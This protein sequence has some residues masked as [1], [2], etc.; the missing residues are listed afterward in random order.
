MCCVVVGVQG[1]VCV[2]VQ[3]VK[4]E[5][6]KS[7]KKEREKC[8]RVVGC[9]LLFLLELGNRELKGRIGSSELLVSSGVRLESGL[10]VCS[11]LVL[12]VNEAVSNKKVCKAREKGKW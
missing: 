4:K 5:R 9:Y 2:C 3:H 6:K 11:V 7:L 10:S 12:G 8:L 1:W